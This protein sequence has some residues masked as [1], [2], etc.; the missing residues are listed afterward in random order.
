MPRQNLP[1]TSWDAAQTAL[2]ADHA[3]ALRRVLDRQNADLLAVAA[4]R[5]LLLGLATRWA[6]WRRGQCDC[7]ETLSPEE[8]SLLE[9][10]AVKNR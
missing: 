2:W 1:Q 3:D 7:D 9:A 10:E 4:Q 6:R 8:R 5:D